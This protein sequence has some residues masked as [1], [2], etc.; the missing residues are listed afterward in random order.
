MYEK[1]VLAVRMMSVKVSHES[2]LRAAQL[3][4]TVREG[5]EKPDSTIKQHIFHFG[6]SKL[7]ER[8]GR[9]IE[10]FKGSDRF[11]V[12]QDFEPQYCNFFKDIIKPTPGEV[13]YYLLV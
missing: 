7:S 13:C 12:D 2:Q 3:L 6:H 4:K 5:Y 10:L 8:W 1:M 11:V 9:M